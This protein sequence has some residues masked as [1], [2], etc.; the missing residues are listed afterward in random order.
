M[1]AKKD[2]QQL[3][4][5]LEGP[6]RKRTAK[7]LLNSHVRLQDLLEGLANSHGYELRKL[8]KEVRK[9]FGEPP[10]DAAD[11]QDS[12]TQEETTVDDE[13]RGQPS[14]QEEDA[15]EKAKRNRRSADDINPTQRHRHA[16]PS[17]KPGDTCPKCGKGKVYPLKDEVLFVIVGAPP[18]SYEAHHR[19]RFR[20]NACQEIFKAPLPE[21]FPKQSRASPSGVV[22]GT[23]LHYQMGVPFFRLEKYQKQIDQRIPIDHLW[24][25]CK[26]CYESVLPVYGELESLA[27]Q[28]MLYHADD[29]TVR[30][31]TLM[32]ENKKNRK[33]PR[34]NGRKDA[35]DRVGMYTTALIAQYAQ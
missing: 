24:E 3:L 1:N 30:I 5:D 8:L 20:C 25:L 32:K 9:L 15:K 2:Y 18:L 35:V 11:S 13:Q 19:E 17:L 26:E 27:A 29:T 34:K 28:A 12:D 14:D 16:H 10:E 4:Q 23:L 21:D 22:N 31:L 33:K 7:E 6:S